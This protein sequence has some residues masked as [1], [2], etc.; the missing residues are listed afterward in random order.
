MASFR[1]GAEPVDVGL[2][3]AHRDPRAVVPPSVLEAAVLE[4]PG[5]EHHPG[6]RGDGGKTEVRRRDGVGR[7]LVPGRHHVRR[8][9]Y[10]DEKREDCELH[11]IN[12]LS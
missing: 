5:A 10:E 12:V 8:T 9:G 6:Y 7:R 1:D 11:F 2:I 3:M 4:V